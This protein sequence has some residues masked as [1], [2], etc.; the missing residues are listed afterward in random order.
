LQNSSILI[1]MFDF[2]YFPFQIRCGLTTDPSKYGYITHPWTGFIGK[3]G[4]A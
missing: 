4:S 3:T 1:K 2:F